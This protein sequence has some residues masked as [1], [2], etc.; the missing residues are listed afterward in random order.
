MLKSKQTRN[1]FKTLGTYVCKSFSPFRVMLSYLSPYPWT[2][3]KS[4]TSR[5]LRNGCYLICSPISRYVCWSSPPHPPLHASNSSSNI[6]SRWRDPL[7]VCEKRKDKEEKKRE[8]TWKHR[9]VVDGICRRLFTLQRLYVCHS[10]LRNCVRSKKNSEFL[11]ST[12]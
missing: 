6:E 4:P 7:R 10:R 8:K 5:R 2:T 11:S 12:C 3:T 9:A 1:Y